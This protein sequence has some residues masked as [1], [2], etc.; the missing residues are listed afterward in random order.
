[1]RLV[2][3]A[4]A[5]L[6]CLALGACSFG[7]PPLTGQARANAETVAACRQQA[8][9]VYEIRNRADIYRPPPAIDTPSS[10]AYAPAGMNDRRLSDLYTHDQLIND[11]V[12]NTGTQTYRGQQPTLRNAP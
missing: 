5:L 8:E 4:A 11:C 6:A 1:M 10:G 7:A 12:R 2:P 9:Q 3:G